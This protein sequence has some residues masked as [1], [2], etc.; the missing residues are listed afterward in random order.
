MD[1]K[2][3]KFKSFIK[4]EGFYVILFV[5]LCVVASVAAITAKNARKANTDNKQS[6]V[7]LEDNNKKSQTQMQNA[8]VVQKSDNKP[9]TVTVPSTKTV[10]NTSKVTFINPIES[11]A[12]VRQ[13]AD[14]IKPIQLQSDKNLFTN[15][16]K[17]V[18]IGAKKG[19]P[20]YAAADGK[21]LEV[22]Q[23]D[24]FNGY[25]V[26]IAH[27]NGMKT[28]YTNLDPAIKVKKGDT[29]KS[30]TEI[31]KV[32]E[33]AISIKQEAYWEALGFQILDSKDLQVDPTKYV[34][35]ATVKN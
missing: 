32:G 12:I 2:N 25:Y 6:V 23:N 14:G 3:N 11:G 20:V 19:T 35:F 13:F 34:S 29:V 18:A 28:V 10:S 1:K 21:V 27:A 7:T 5:C 4:K 16:I 9:A 15:L 8:E 33:S 22:G 24:L 17:G 26:K 30:K 31:G